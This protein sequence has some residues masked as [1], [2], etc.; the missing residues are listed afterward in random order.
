M[1]QKSVAILGGGYIGVELGEA[2][3]VAVVSGSRVNALK[4]TVEPYEGTVTLE[5]G[6]T[7]EADLVIPAIA[8]KPQTSFFDDLPGAVKAADGRIKV[9]EY[10][11]PSSLPKVF[12]AGDAIDAGDQ[13]TIV[14]A[15]RQQP[16]LAK[17]LKAI[18]AGK[19]MESQKAYTPCGKAPI[20]TPLGP[21]KRSSFSVL[22]TFG[23]W[24]TK[25]IKGKFLFISKYRKTLGYS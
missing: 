16:W 3:E 17:L 14:A 18:I 6:Q 10:L 12:A 23:T 24:V 15:S 9:D 22:G 25:S 5:T 1:G 8:S 20:L 21:A 2:L 13:M 11:R 19:S 7:I 4:S